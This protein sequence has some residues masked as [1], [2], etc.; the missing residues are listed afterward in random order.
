MK[1]ILNK[2]STPAIF[3]KPYSRCIHFPSRAN[4]FWRSI[5]IGRS[6]KLVQNLIGKSQDGVR[7]C[8]GFSISV[9]LMCLSDC[10]D[11]RN[12]RVK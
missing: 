10:F 9:A 6:A 12:G 1:A 8:V 4:L 3:A 5:T 7:A 11:S 2:L